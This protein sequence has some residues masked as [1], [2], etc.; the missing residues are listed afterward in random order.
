MATFHVRGLGLALLLQWAK[1]V[2]TD[3]RP[4]SK[5]STMIRR[6]RRKKT[7]TFSFHFSFSEPI[8][9]T[10]RHACFCF[11]QIF[12][13]LTAQGQNLIPMLKLSKLLPGTWYV[14]TQMTHVF[15]TEVQINLNVHA[16][17]WR[18]TQT[19][20]ACL[21]TCCMSPCQ[22]VDQRFFFFSG[23]T[24]GSLQTQISKK[25]Q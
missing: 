3:Y 10:P 21:H 22:A 11:T 12:K 16:V 9:A 19:L 17:F 4:Y 1:R 8:A 7:K 2:P 6:F 5:R 24:F 20:I 14:T 15:R 25:I 13:D 18:Y 23:G